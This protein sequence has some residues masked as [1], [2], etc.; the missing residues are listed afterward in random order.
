MGRQLGRP[1]AAVACLL[2]AALPLTAA[3]LGGARAGPEIVGDVQHVFD[4]GIIVVDERPIRLWGVVAP[5]IG[6]PFSGDSQLL[7]RKATLGRQARCEPLF[8]EAGWS[9]RIVARCL[10]G[11]MDL[12]A[13]LIA[14]GFGSPCAVD[15]ELPYGRLAPR[16]A[17]LD[18]GAAVAC[19][20]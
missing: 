17:R 10:V 11:A 3:P 6:E 8:G 5:R 14:S 18:S 12:S 20:R 2:L 9:R 13:L 4:R 15:G 19:P 1:L 16:F 7:L